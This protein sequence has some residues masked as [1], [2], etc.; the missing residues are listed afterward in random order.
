MDSCF[1]SEGLIVAVDTQWNSI[2]FTVPP[3]P[4]E[5]I[6]QW[7]QVVNRSVIAGHLTRQGEAL[8]T[9]LGHQ[10]GLLTITELPALGEAE[11][12]VGDFGGLYTFAF[13]PTSDS[14]E[15]HVSAA[16]AAF[17]RAAMEVMPPLDLHLP[18][19]VMALTTRVPWDD[20]DWSDP[21]LNRDED[22]AFVHEVSLAVLEFPIDGTMYEG[23]VGWGWDSWQVEAYRYLFI[24]LSVGCELAVEHR[25]SGQRIHLTADVGW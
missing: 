3:A 23:L 5:L 9:R 24:P 25:P 18:K 8:V 11:P 22:T 12:Y 6:R 20:L 16:P 4:T 14:C 13:S 7:Q 17:T 21:Q 15:L 19:D 10:E 1:P 2:V